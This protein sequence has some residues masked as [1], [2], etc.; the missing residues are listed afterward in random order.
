MKVPRNAEDLIEED[1]A[2]IVRAREGLRSERRRFSGRYVENAHLKEWKSRDA[3][4]YSQLFPVPMCTISHGNG[5][6][7]CGSA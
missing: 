6:L 4:W 1:M 5:M 2:W 7:R 3:V